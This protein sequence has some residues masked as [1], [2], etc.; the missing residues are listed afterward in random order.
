[1]PCARPAGRAICVSSATA[2]SCSTTCGTTGEYADGRNAPRP[3]LILLDLKMPRKDGRE[4]LR[5]LKADPRWRHIPV[6]VLTTSTAGDDVDFSY[7]VGR[8]LLRHQADHVPRAGRNPGHAGQVLV[9][10]GRIAAQGVPWWKNALEILLVEDD[11]D[12]VW[13]MRNL[14][15]D[16]WDGPFELVQVELLSAAIERCDEDQFDVILLDLTPARQPRP[17]DLLRHARPRRRRADRRALGLQRR[18][19]RPSRPCRPAPRTTWSR[20]R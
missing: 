20:A 4:T 9:R 8:Q 5:E 15:G 2:R 14:L 11:P 7:D 13:V 10:G 17:G 19:Q 18:G 6:V 12:D 3:D 16:R 1:M